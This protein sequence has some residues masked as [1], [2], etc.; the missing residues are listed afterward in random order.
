MPIRNPYLSAI[1]SGQTPSAAA[2]GGG[3]A[4]LRG[5]FEALKGGLDAGGG[6]LTGK[7]PGGGMTVAMLLPMILG[8]LGQSQ[9]KD[10][11]GRVRK[12][13]DIEH[14]E[15]M[16]GLM[17]SDDAYYQSMM[18]ELERENELVQALLM[19]Q[20]AGNQGPRLASGEVAIGGKG[21]AY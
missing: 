2:A 13:R 21:R 12:G 5:G 4:S 8:M 7:I 18:P 11:G 17:S 9:I 3:E 6:G 20:L 15:K 1:M 16:T 19:Q 10:I 14:M